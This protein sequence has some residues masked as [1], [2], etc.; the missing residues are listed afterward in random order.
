MD[1]LRLLT[2]IAGGAWLAGCVLLGVLSLLP[3][4]RSRVKE[5]WP[6]MVS[7]AA[8]LGAGTLLWLLPHSL[9]VVP[10]LLAAARFGFESGKVNGGQDSSFAG[11]ITALSLALAAMLVWI[12]SSTLML[13]FLFLGMLTGIVI[14]F[15]MSSK[16]LS[17][18]FRTLL[19]PT[20]PFLLFV[21]AATKPDTGTVFILSLL[22]VEVFDSFALLGGKLFGRHLMVPKLSP[23]KTWEGFGVGLAAALLAGAALSMMTILPAP[24]VM[25]IALV[26]TIAA[27]AGDLLASA[28]KRRAGVKDY[29]ALLRSQGGLLDIYDAWIVAAPAAVFTVLVLG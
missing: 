12:T 24:T 17:R 2:V 11:A 13:F 1:D 5:L 27:V 14:G 20:L 22:I 3:N 23:K 10:L 8:I 21:L 28:A 26:S 4:T 19:F 15:S 25:A 7:E 6:L 9:L 16:P 18:L 29:P